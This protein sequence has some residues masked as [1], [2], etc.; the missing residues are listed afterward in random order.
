[1][2]KILIISAVLA[3]LAGALYFV[4]KGDFFSENDAKV[5]ATPESPE[6]IKARKKAFFELMETH[7]LN[8][9]EAV[10]Q[11]RLKLLDCYAARSE[12]QTANA[13]MLQ[14]CQTFINILAK[15]Y[16]LE[17][18]GSAKFWRRLL[19]RVDVVPLSLLMAQA[20]IES[21][22]GRSRFAK[23]GNNYFGQWCFKAGCGIVP[24]KRTDG[25]N[26]EVASFD[27]VSGSVSAYILNLNRHRSYESFRTARLIARKDDRPIKSL[28][29]LAGLNGYSERGQSYLKDVRSVIRSNK[30]ER[31]DL[32]RAYL[33]KLSE[34]AM[35]PIQQQALAAIYASK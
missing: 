30:L 23:L 32:D 19:G 18:D 10:Y 27:S 29:L 34:A 25:A 3:L 22:W 6:Q 21:S 1:M 11:D 7:G 8:A 4:F 5:V 14:Q 33:V 16:R 20:A 2:R 17:N 31:Y 24:A 28:E 9:N 35:S 13:S 12:Q 26:H 15:R